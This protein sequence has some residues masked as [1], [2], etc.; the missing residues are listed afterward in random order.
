MTTLD[1]AIV[2]AAGRFPGA[3]DLQSFWRN[4]RDGVDSISRWT[5]PDAAVVGAEGL[6]EGFDCFDAEFF[7]Y[8]PREARLIDPQHRVFLECGVHALESA[9]L[10]PDRYR[11]RIGVYASASLGGY[12]LNNACGAPEA[13]SAFD[14]L[15]SN[16]KDFLATRLSYKLNLRGPGVMIQTACS[17]SLV[18]VHFAC[19]G[20]LSGDCD[21][22]LTG[23]VTVRSPHRSGYRAMRGM[24]FSPDGVCR[25]FDR[26]AAGSVPGNGV[27]ATVLMRLDDALAGRHSIL[28]IIRGTA[29][30]N[31]GQRKPSY[32]AP[33]ADGQAAA[34]ASALAAARAEPHEVGFVEAH[35]SGT[36]LGD[37]IEVRGLKKVFG[38]TSAE[39][40]CA[41]GSVKSNVGHL[42]AVSGITGL[43]KAA[44]SLHH[45]T[46]PPTV[47]YEFPN[48]DLRLEGSPFYVNRAART[49]P[50]GSARLAGVSSF[51]IGGTNA[52][53]ILAAAP[54]REVRAPGRR[55]RLMPASAENTDALTT[56][57]G[58][59]ADSLHDVEGAGLRDAARTL[60]YGRRE[61]PWRTFAVGRDGVEIA[62]ALRRP[63]VHASTSDRWFPVFAFPGLGSQIQGMGRELYAAF[64]VFRDAIDT[65][66]RLVVT[67][68]APDIREHLLADTG[69]DGVQAVLRRGAATTDAEIAEVAHPALFALEYALVQLWSSVGLRPSAVCGFSLGEYV[70]ATV[71]GVLSLEDALTL[72][73]HRARIVDALPPG[74]MLAAAL[75][76]EELQAHLPEDIEIAAFCGPHQTVVAGTATAIERLHASLT[77][78]T[79]ACRT[80]R[81]RHAFHSTLMR[82]VVDAV[83][84]LAAA[85]PLGPPT[86]PMLSNVTGDWVAAGDMSVPEYWARHIASPIRWEDSLSRI[87]ALDQPLIVE[88]GPGSSLTALA[89]QHPQ[90]RGSGV[91]ATLPDPQAQEAGF[92]SAVG[93]VWTHG[94]AVRWDALEPAEEQGDAAF[95]QLPGYPFRRERHWIEPAAAPRGDVERPAAARA[96]ADEADR[97]TEHPASAPGSSTDVVDAVEAIFAK[98][99]GHATLPAG[100]SFFELGGDSLLALK[101]A[102]AVET[103]FEVAVPLQILHE[104]ATPRQ[105][106]SWLEKRRSEPVS[107]DAIA[108]TPASSSAPTDS[109]F[110]LAELTPGWND[111]AAGY[112]LAAL[113]RLR[114][115][116]ERDHAC[117]IDALPFS[118]DRRKLIRRWMDELCARRILENDGGVYRALTPVEL[119]PPP[120]FAAAGGTGYA[121]IAAFLQQIGEGLVDI[122]QHRM[123]PS[124]LAFE[125]H[126]SVALRAYRDIA[127]AQFCLRHAAAIVGRLAS[128]QPRALDI[129]EIGGGLAV[130]TAA[131][132]PV[133]VPSTRYVF[134]DVSPTFLRCGV[135]A[136]PAAECRIWDIDANPVSYGLRSHSFDLVVSTNVLHCAASIPASLEHIRSLLKPEG[137]L[138]LVE[139]TRNELWHTLSMGLLDGFFRFQDDRLASGMTFLSRDAWAARLTA[140]GFGIERISPGTDDGNADIGQHVML[141]VRG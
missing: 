70:A 106:A 77:A 76:P 79:V 134:T 55:V 98:V 68:H 26:R 47:H 17:S 108:P 83:A 48:P 20:L 110:I 69:P 129:L 12:L 33:Q 45:R 71:A 102:N 50:A 95:V 72:I 31:D 9:A 15:L 3:T 118:S 14:L 57:T 82:D 117:R 42:D 16:D 65:C 53:V 63:T 34:I 78:R 99:L 1:V 133:L 84:G 112:V 30:N 35:G 138:L 67:Q 2:G 93:R 19:L 121:A 94:C 122:L 88:V 73:V 11:G 32:T 22:A 140:A 64:P 119:R 115:L 38:E 91:L 59:L 101:L 18:A 8:S 114:L 137:R 135:E 61:R 66:A 97:H 113:H 139:A 23:G 60:Q 132:A 6:L 5:A 39:P 29:I 100:R 81:T 36:P 85:V 49:W 40:W 120:P 51:G 80:L 7:G 24:I 28:A 96:A 27:A 21:A 87:W 25:P 125:G 37:L 54:P 4:A 46:I 131:I 103:V 56:L 136:F 109:R 86:L 126:P 52:H 10:D 141:A 44:L 104:H 62:G 111:A 130:T 107:F 13:E 43:L 41:L 123:D 92:V 90:S 128:A 89:L 105:F 127:E 74:G 124:R 75:G 116:P 58:R